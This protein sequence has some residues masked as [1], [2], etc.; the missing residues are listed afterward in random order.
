MIFVQH[1]YTNK[2]N[3]IK[4]MEKFIFPHKSAQF[5]TMGYSYRSSHSSPLYG[6]K[7]SKSRLLFRFKPIIWPILSA[8]AGLSTKKNETEYI[9]TMNYSKSGWFFSKI[10]PN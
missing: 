6:L 7:H 2:T 3:T 4:K 10:S 1:G 9:E 8:K 5:D